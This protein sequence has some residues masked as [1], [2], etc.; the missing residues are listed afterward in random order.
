M[1][2]GR[3]TRL[4]DGIWEIV[5]AKLTLRCSSSWESMKAQNR[6]TRSLRSL[7][8]VCL[9]PYLDIIANVPDR[10]IWLLLALGPWTTHSTTL[11]QFQR[12]EYSTYKESLFDVTGE[13][14]KIIFNS[15]CTEFKTNPE[16][17]GKALIKPG[18]R[19]PG[20]KFYFCYSL[21]AKWG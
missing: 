16:K 3:K 19:M 13:F 21:S 12:W 10:L 18:A 8:Q 20:F 15:E 14:L 6:S 4:R 9:C 17:W 5:W 1:I 7:C 11:L 2:L